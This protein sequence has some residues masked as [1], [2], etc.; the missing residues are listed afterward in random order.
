MFLDDEYLDM[1]RFGCDANNIFI[2]NGMRLLDIPILHAILSSINPNALPTMEK[3]GN[4]FAVSFEQSLL[5]KQVVFLELQYF[6]SFRQLQQ[7]QNGN[8]YSG[9][10]LHQIFKTKEVKRSQVY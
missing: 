9:Y 3:Y 10:W 7:D 8:H 2:S 5:N 4:S 6:Y 1:K